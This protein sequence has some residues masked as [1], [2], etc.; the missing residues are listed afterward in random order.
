LHLIRIDLSP[1]GELVSSTGEKTVATSELLSPTGEK[2][3]STGELRFF[4]Q[5][6]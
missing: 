4:H 6:N 1:T 2:K 5:L 3:T